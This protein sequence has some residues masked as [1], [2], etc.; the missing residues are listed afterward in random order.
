VSFA[1][2][3]L[4]VREDRAVVAVEHAVDQGEGA[5]LVDEA[6]GAVGCEDVIERKGFRGL[7]AVLAHQ[8]YLVVLAVHLHHVHA[9]ALQLLAVHRTHSHHH[10]HAFRHT[11]TDYITYH[12]AEPPNRQDNWSERDKSYENQWERNWLEPISQRML[13]FSHL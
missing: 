9:P 13:C 6:L 3:G 11:Q 10:S 5:L 8:I 7:L 1:A 2:T 12:Q 4:S